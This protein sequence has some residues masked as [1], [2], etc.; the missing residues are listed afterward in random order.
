MDSQVLLDVAIIGA[1][2]SGLYAGW[3][4]LQDPPSKLSSSTPKGLPP[5]IQVF[6]MS[7]R[8]GGRLLSVVPPGMPHVVCELGGM[9]YTSTQTL[10]RGL[11]EDVLKLNTHPFPVAESNNLAYLRGKRLRLQELSDPNKVPY[12]LD[13]PERDVPVSSLI[14]YAIN[15]LIPGF[16]SLTPY[17]MRKTLQNFVFDGKPFYKQGFWNVLLRVLSDEAFSYT[18]DAGGYES[19]VHNFNAVD[20]TL[21]NLADFTGDVTFHGVTDGFESVPLALSERFLQLGGQLHMGHRLQ[22]MKATTLE[23]QSQGVALH[24]EGRESPV[25]A[26]HVILAMPRRSLELIDPS[27]VGLSLPRTKSLIQSVQGFPFFKMFLCYPTPWWNTLGIQQGQSV[28]DLP[29]RQCYYWGVEGQ[30]WGAD[31]KNT[32]AALLAS[33]DDGNN[34]DFWAGLQEDPTEPRFL[35]RN[36]PHAQDT[37]LPDWDN[38]SAPAGMVDELHRQLQ[39]MHG[40]R[41]VPE[42]YAA[43]YMDWAIDPYGGAVNFWQRGAKSWEVIPAITKPASDLPV[44]IC[45]SAYSNHQGWVEGALE[46]AEYMLEHHFG[47]S[48]PSWAD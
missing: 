21:L 11:V 19:V 35:T 1:G 33:Y 9:R 37:S 5:N 6:E 10:V 43:A 30:Q 36:N 13:Y 46:T 24:F 18:R 7:Q 41:Y 3:R 29:L 40:V 8:I 44:Y 14:S 12:V 32:N 15:Q 31:P 26:R 4:L 2:V 23:D 27:S 16:S 17:Q 28:T 39:A 42:P 22:C 38:Y 20:M 34:V 25:Y 47:L 45:G 48:K